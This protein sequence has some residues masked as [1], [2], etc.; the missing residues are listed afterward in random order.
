MWVQLD[1]IIDGGR[2]MEDDCL[3]SRLGSTVVNLAEGGKFT[4]I[5]AGR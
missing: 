1:L 4:I 2:I 3:E 5:R